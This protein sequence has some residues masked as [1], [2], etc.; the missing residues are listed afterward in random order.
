M[1]LTKQGKADDAKKRIIKSITQEE[2][3]I[4]IDDS[5]LEKSFYQRFFAPWVARVS[6]VFE[7]RRKQR[8]E[9]NGQ[10]V[11]ERT[12]E[13]IQKTEQLL[14]MSGMHTTYQN[15][16]FFKT[17]F[18]IIFVVIVVGIAFILNSDFMITVL[19]VGIGLVLAFFLPDFFL[20]LLVSS[21]Q[22]A[23]KDQLPDVLDLLSVCTEAGLSFDGALLKVIEKMDGAFIDELMTVFR[24]MQMGISRNQALER[25]SECTDI[26][27]LKTFVSAV[28]QSTQLGI[29]I[30]NVLKVQAQQIRD[31]RLEAARE[32][33]NKAA[34]I[35]AIPTMFF[36]FPSLFIVI[37]GPT[38]INIKDTI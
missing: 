32:K 9:R 21:H 14:R 28:V 27:E 11:N 17:A 29:P 22:K 16:N 24:Q 38:V 20:K 13:R 18:A 19:L 7:D 5:E 26:P 23:I 4:K 6:N 34:T 37:L 35:I 1:L 15:Y 3:L 30:N 10:V 25:L 33:G 2:E 36:I 8:Q 31:T 12:V